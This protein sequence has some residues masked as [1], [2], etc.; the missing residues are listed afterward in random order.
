MEGL[1]REGEVNG[2]GARSL[3]PRG[4]VR[5]EAEDWPRGRQGSH[6]GCTAVRRAGAAGLGLKPA[7]TERTWELRVYTRE[8]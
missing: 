8:F 7:H 3:E 5:T 6:A 4:R 2:A 1:Q